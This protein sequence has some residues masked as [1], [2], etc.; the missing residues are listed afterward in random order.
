MFRDKNKTLFFY[1]TAHVSAIVKAEK[2]K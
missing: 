2:V 1:S